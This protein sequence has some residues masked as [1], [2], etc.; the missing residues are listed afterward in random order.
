MRRKIMKHQIERFS[1]H[2][3]AKVFAVIMAVIS[4]V[5][6][7]PFVLFTVASTPAPAQMR[8][9]VYLF[10]F[11]PIFYLVFGYIMVAIGCTFY[12]FIF[13]YLGGFEYESRDE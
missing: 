5:G 2:Q 13:K 12:N 8:L 7:I 4:L 3:N 10:I 11:F 6:F 9:P 1:P